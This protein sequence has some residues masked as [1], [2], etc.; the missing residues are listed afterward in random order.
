MSLAHLS[1][2]SRSLAV[3]PVVLTAGMAL[4]TN[5]LGTTDNNQLEVRVNN[6]R[7]GFLTPSG[8]T[9]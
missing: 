7:A 9:T 8:T 4:G 3:W 5:F 1:V 2:K 6:E